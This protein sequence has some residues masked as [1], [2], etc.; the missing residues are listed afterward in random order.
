SRQEI[1]STP[2][3]LLCGTHLDAQDLA[4]LTTPIV[5]SVSVDH[6]SEGDI[7]RLDERG[8]VRTLYRRQSN[9]NTL[10]ATE[11]CNSLCLMCSQPPRDINDDWRIEEMLDVVSLMDPATEAL[12]ITG[13]EPSLLGEGLLKV[14]RTCRDTLPRTALHVLSNGRLFRYWPFA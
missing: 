3:A 7:V 14:I 4:G 2:D 5:Y 8:L 10:F 11:R 9:H 13:G 12:G 6:L 1:A